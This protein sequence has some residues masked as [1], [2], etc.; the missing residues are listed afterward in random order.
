[1][2]PYLDR[3]GLAGLVLPDD[4]RGVAVLASDERQLEQPIFILSGNLARDVRRRRI[5]ARAAYNSQAGI[6][7]S[8][9]HGKIMLPAAA[10]RELAA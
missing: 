6:R 3:E 2:G 8:V 9:R 10:G 5:S 4:A 1:V 7:R